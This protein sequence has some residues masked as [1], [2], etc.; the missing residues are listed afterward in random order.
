MSNKK[1]ICNHAKECGEQCDTIGTC[2][3]TP[4]E[5]DLFCRKATCLKSMMVVE[6][7]EVEDAI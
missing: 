1:V 3:K 4:H 2:H 7:V 5:K 6:C